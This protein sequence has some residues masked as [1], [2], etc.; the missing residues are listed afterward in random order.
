VTFVALATGVAMTTPVLNAAG[1]LDGFPF[2][3]QWYV[4]AVDTRTSFAMF[5]W[6]GF[7]FAGAATGILLANRSYRSTANPSN[8]SNLFAAL[9]LGV[10]GVGFYSATLPTIYRSS[11]FWTSSP[12]F[13]AIRAGILMLA[14]AGASAIQSVVGGAPR[15]VHVALRWLERFGR[16]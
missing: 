14:L 8:L 9:G 5:P 1:W 15:S 10:L 7:V 4:R 3:L 2:W 6:S 11:S 13:F 16:A 12:S